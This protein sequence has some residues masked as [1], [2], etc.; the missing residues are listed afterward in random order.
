MPSGD[1]ILTIYIAGAIAVAVG[2]GIWRGFF[3]ARKIQPGGFR[4]RTFRNEIFF[5]VI[6]LTVSATLLVW[7]RQYFDAQGWITFRSGTAPWYVIGLEYALYFFL[8]DTWF[9]WGH[10]LMHVEPIYKWVHRVH[11]WSTSPNPLTT[12]SE[13]P[14]EAII[15]GIF[16]TLFVA[17]FPVHDATMA[18]I[19]PTA[20][21]MG[22]YV[23]S[24]FEF[25]PRWWN[26][27]WLSKWFITATFHDQHH[28]YFRYNFGGYTPIWDYLCGTN[29][30]KYEADFDKLKDRAARSRKVQDAAGLAEG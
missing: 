16:V 19:A 9:Y 21:L 25:L 18:L 30:N 7:T 22:L 26:R 15:N 24:G 12:F 29:R 3:Q 10:R 14:M 5:A 11:H 2:L 8:F 20:P 23:H 4:L 6:T 28:K 1:T 27:S 17:V 13:T